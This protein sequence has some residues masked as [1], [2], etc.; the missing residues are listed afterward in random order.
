MERWEIQ[1]CQCHRQEGQKKADDCSGR[2]FLSRKRKE[3]GTDDLIAENREDNG[4]Q[5]NF[6]VAE[7]DF[8][9]V[10]KREEGADR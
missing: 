1:P 2:F 7:V 6:C 4:A 5:D 10:E 3:V 8:P 9:V